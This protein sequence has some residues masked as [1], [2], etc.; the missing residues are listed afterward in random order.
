MKT[1]RGHPVRQCGQQAQPLATDIVPSDSLFALRAQADRMS[2]L[3]LVALLLLSILSG[4]LP[5]C[6]RPILRGNK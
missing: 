6:C 1:D 2:A 4:F 5:I 3:R